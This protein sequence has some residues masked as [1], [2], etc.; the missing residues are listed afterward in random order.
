MTQETTGRQ[1]VLFKSDQSMAESCWLQGMDFPGPPQ[2]SCTGSYGPGEPSSKDLQGP[3]GEMHARMQK[4]N[5]NKTKN[6][7][8]EKRR[9][10][11]NRMQ[12]HLCY[13]NFLAYSTDYGKGLNKTRSEINLP[14]ARRFDQMGTLSW[15]MCPFLQ[16]PST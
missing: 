11:M 5:A 6:G 8:L 10:N 9:G 16:S 15:L 14:K 12:Q 1:G 3:A 2:L 7:G 4:R 13:F